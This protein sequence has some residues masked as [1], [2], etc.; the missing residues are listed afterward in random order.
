MF[1][2]LFNLGKQK[3][4]DTPVLSCKQTVYKRYKLS[5]NNSAKVSEYKSGINLIVTISTKCRT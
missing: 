3:A 5:H 4:V 1:Q 2:F